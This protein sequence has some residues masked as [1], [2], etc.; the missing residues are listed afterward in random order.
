LKSIEFKEDDWVLLKEH[1][2]L[3]KNRKLAEN[4]KDHLGLSK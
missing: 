3:H 4:S 2:F 1:Y